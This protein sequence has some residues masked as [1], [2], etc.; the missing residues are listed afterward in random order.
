MGAGHTRCTCR[1]GNRVHARTTAVLCRGCR[2]I[3]PAAA[4]VAAHSQKTP[5]P[6]AHKQIA[7]IV[8]SMKQQTSSAAGRILPIVCLPRQ[9]GLL[10]SLAGRAPTLCQGQSG[11]QPNCSW[12]KMP[13]PSLQPENHPRCQKHLANS[14]RCPLGK[15]NFLMHGCTW[16]K[17]GIAPGDGPS[18]WT[19]CVPAGA[20]VAACGPIASCR[21]SR[22]QS[23]RRPRTCSG[24]LSQPGWDSRLSSSISAVLQI[25][26]NPSWT[27]AC[28]KLQPLPS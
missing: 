4:R 6:A 19:S 21:T 11:T 8:T 10:L 26:P 20:A 5:L 12:V 24:R 23:R 27:G 18:G 9:Y 22:G 17:R 13:K 15:C 7:P 25:T 28:T 2:K 3:Q 16:G 1:S 14:K